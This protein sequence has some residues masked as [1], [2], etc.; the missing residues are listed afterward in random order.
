MKSLLHVLTLSNLGDICHNISYLIS[1]EEYK[2]ITRADINQA[3]RKIFPKSHD[4]TSKEEKKKNINDLNSNNQ[5]I[6]DQNNSSSSNPQTE[7]QQR[8]DNYFNINTG[9]NNTR[10]PQTTTRSRS[11]WNNTQNRYI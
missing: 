2:R 6:T 9:D 11:T 4:K 1:E 3:P 10:N 8:M 7:N 5:Q